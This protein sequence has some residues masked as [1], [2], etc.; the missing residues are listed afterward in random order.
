MEDLEG[1]RFTGTFEIE[2]DRHIFGDLTL[3]G[4]DTR[5]YLR[6]REFFSPSKLADQSLHGIL[7]DLRKVSLLYCRVRSEGRSGRHGQSYESAELTPSFVFF[8]DSHVGPN[9]EVITEIQFEIDDATTLF[10]D[11]DAFGRAFEPEK[12]IAKVTDQAAKIGRKI[13]IGPEPQIYYFAGQHE[14]FASETAIGRIS[15][16][17]NMHFRFPGPEGIRIDNAILLNVRFSEPIA[18]LQAMERLETTMRFAEL[19]IGR[20]QH[21]R[22]IEVTRQKKT[23]EPDSLRVYWCGAPK[24]ERLRFGPHPSDVLLDAVRDSESFQKVL[25]KWVER[26]PVWK[27]GRSRFATC[28]AKQNHF[29]HDRLIGAANMFDILPASALPNRVVVSPELEAAKQQAKKLFEALPQSPERSSVLSALGRIGGN[30]LKQKVRYRVSLI[31]RELGDKFPRLSLV[32]DEAINCR[33]HY[34]HGSDAPL[35]YEDNF[36]LV[37][38]FTKTLEFVFGASDLIE[39]GWNIQ[40]WSRHSTTL[41]HPFDAW[42]IDYDANLQNL[43]QK[44]GIE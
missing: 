31:E 4:R 41:S 32:T 7:H 8:G 1:Q 28:F 26:N 25:N 23:G 30:S 36:E 24:H 22:R 3:A 39:A 16:E 17:H 11:V 27:D 12:F 19:L 33:N 29:D 34:V 21:L 40:K 18:F 6:D 38:F 5:L 35:S 13:K 10:Y 43:V 20:P 42:R 44:Y 37:I 9:D 2:L 15:A 14:I